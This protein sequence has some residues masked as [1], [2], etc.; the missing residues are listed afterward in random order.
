MVRAPSSSASKINSVAQVLKVAQCEDQA[1]AACRSVL[2][3]VAETSFIVAE[4]WVAVLGATLGAIRR[5]L[6][7]TAADARGT[8]SLSFRAVWTAV[9][10]HRHRL[11]IYGSEGWGFE[12]SRACCE[13]P[14]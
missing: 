7:W 12:F 9:D 6:V 3:A 2:S 5:G 14:A 10:T 1:V 13:T 11:E 8:E 4:R